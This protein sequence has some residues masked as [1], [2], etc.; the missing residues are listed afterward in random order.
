[1]NFSIVTIFPDILKSFIKYGLISKAIEKNLINVHIYDL[2]DFSVDK[3]KKVDDRPFGG[4]PGMVLKPEPLFNVINFIKKRKK[5]KVIL[6]SAYGELLSQQK[7]KKLSEEEHLILICGRY[8]G[9]DQRVIDNL[10]DQ[11][12]SIG[13]YVLMGGE[14]AAEVVIESVS[15]MFKGV[16]GKMES[17]ESDSFFFKDQYAIPQYTQPRNFKG[18]KVPEILLSGNHK[19]IAEWRKKNRKKKNFM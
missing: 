19:D 2:R 8:E 3:H 18:M 1:M 12:I 14:I 6:F 13:E 10:V 15:R 9:V 17:V 4:G 16:V 5:G 7:V 11:E